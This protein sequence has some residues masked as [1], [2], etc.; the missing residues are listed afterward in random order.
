MKTILALAL[1]LLTVPA[2]GQV[3]IFNDSAGR[4][5]STWSYGNGLG[6]YQD[7]TSTTGTFNQMGRQG[8]YADSQGTI[9][10]WMDLG[11]GM[12]VYNDS[13]GGTGSSMDLGGGLGTYQYQSPKGSTQGS[14]M[15]VGPR[16]R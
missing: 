1:L 4:T 8:F 6:T 16:S 13:K 5:G 10:S 9:G 2:Y 3:T 14:Y 11:G 12:R 15:Q 7:S